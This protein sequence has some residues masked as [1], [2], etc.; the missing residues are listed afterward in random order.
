MA[1][2]PIFLDS[3][4]PDVGE[5]VELFMLDCRDLTGSEDD[6]YYFTTALDWG[7][8]IQWK[9]INYPTINEIVTYS[10]LDIKAEGFQLSAN[11]SLPQPTLEI[12]NVSVPLL[13][14]LKSYND[15]VGAKVRR[16]R[17]LGKYISGALADMMAHF[18]EDR[19]I[20]SQKIE[21]DPVHIKWKLDCALDSTGTKLPSRLIT[22]DFCPFVYRRWNGNLDTAENIFT[23]DDSEERCPIYMSHICLA[24]VTFNTNNPWAGVAAWAWQSDGSGAWIL[25]SGHAVHV[26]NSN[27]LWRALYCPTLAVPG[28]I[29]IARVN[30]LSISGLVYVRLGELGTWSSAI[31]TTGIHRVAVTCA[32][33]ESPYLGTYPLFSLIM[34][35]PGSVSIQDASLDV[36]F[37]SG[38]FNTPN[39]YE[40]VCNKRVSGC[41]ARFN[42]WVLPFGG[43]PGVSRV[44]V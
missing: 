34:E 1:D 16:Y 27:G 13:S 31:S 26:A 38:N 17:T 9:G 3:Y 33:N 29:Y 25:D 22:K 43:F 4:Q 39:P 11:G 19:Y 10:A 36:Y 7:S 37:T 8:L 6:V 30:V 40:D 21:H 41:H 5:Y 44:R 28:Q 42:G 12:S 20:I 2:N 24:D 18:P 23:Y 14:V 32:A 35:D 15:L